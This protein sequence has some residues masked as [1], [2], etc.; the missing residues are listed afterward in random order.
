MSDIILPDLD[1][2]GLTPGVGAPP[3]PAPVSPAP[4]PLPQISLPPVAPIMPPQPQIQPIQATPAPRAPQVPTPAPVPDPAPPVAPQKPT[5][6]FTV[7]VGIA[8]QAQDM[9][10]MGGE[11]NKTDGTDKKTDLK[12]GW[13]GQGKG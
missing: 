9:Y 13:G 6:K 2:S 1:L 12:Q 5:H 4:A 8:K 3:S 7:P 11:P 10:K